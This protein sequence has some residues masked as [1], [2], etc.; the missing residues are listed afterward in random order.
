MAGGC[1]K[2]PASFS[3]ISNSA[4]SGTTTVLLKPQYLSGDSVQ[5]SS[6]C[7]A[8]ACSWALISSPTSFLGTLDPGRGPPAREPAAVVRPS[9]DAATWRYSFTLSHA[10]PSRMCLRMGNGATCQPPGTSSH[11]LRRDMHWCLLAGF[12]VWF[13]MHALL[14]TSTV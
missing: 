8:R 11:P 9:P 10:H 5:G 14:S 13:Y 12:Q 4:A 2:E 3:E 1:L 7:G 6:R